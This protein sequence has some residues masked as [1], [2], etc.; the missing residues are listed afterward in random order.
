MDNEPK[1]M[2]IHPLAAAAAVAVILVCLVGIAAMT[3]ILPNFSKAPDPVVATTPTDL[4][5]GATSS[6]PIANATTEEP[7]AAP[8][9][10][11]HVV[12]KP[13]VV[14]R[15]TVPTSPIA[16]PVAP[17]PVAPP[18]PPCLNCGVVESARAIEQQA[19]ASGLGAAAGAVLGGVLGH[20]VG[21]GNGKTLATIAGAV[22]GGLAGNAVE[23]NSK[24]STAYEVI[25]LMDNGTRQRFVM[26]EQRWRSGD[27]VQV[28]NG[29]L[30]ARTQ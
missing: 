14:A 24:T 28:N 1:K 13:A 6:Q 8:P 21:G 26:N 29:Y 18:P 17:M 27:L 3:G 30:V 9:V 4:T 16:T 25:V 11:K 22:G 2:K 10:K 15:N 20:Q 7:P 12:K 23:K 5:P 19:P